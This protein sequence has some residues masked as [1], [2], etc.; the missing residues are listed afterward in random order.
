LDEALPDLLSGKYAD[1]R[2]TSLAHL[3]PLLARRIP[4]LVRLPVLRA[5]LERELGGLVAEALESERAF[6]DAGRLL[7]DEYEQRFERR[8]EAGDLLLSFQADRLDRGAGGAAHV[9]DYKSHP[10]RQDRVK[11]A[12][13]SPETLQVS[14]YFHLLAPQAAPAFSVVHMGSGMRPRVQPIRES[15]D[16]ARVLVDG[17]LALAAELARAWREL[18]A[19]PWPDEVLNRKRDWRPECVYC[20]FRTVCRGDHEPTRRRLEQSPDLKALREAL[21]STRTSAEDDAE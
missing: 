10:G 18:R 13:L 21:P 17:A 20:D 12:T 6:L 19:S 9:T 16:A 4:V 15:G 7:P 1:A 14:L 8:F 5:A 11:N 2:A 3:P